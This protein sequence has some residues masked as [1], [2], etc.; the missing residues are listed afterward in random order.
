[1]NQDEEARLELIAAELVKLNERG[2][3]RFE[4]NAQD[5]FSFVA[6]LQLAWRHPRLNPKQRR[7]IEEF[8][9]SLRQALSQ[10]PELS[11]VIEEGWDRNKDT[12]A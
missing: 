11:R 6:L 9:D 2:P 12:R 4:M 1:M 7:M 5:A 8:V 10:S 3:I